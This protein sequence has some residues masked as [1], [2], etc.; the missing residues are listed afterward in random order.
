[1]AKPSAS[2]DAQTSIFSNPQDNAAGIP[3]F[4]E[5]CNALYERE[6]T[7]L[8]LANYRDITLL[9]RR[10]RGLPY[11]IK[12]AARF[13]SSQSTPL[14]VDVHNAS[15]I[16]KQSSARPQVNADP[17]VTRKWF[18]QH[19]KFGLA[20]PVLVKVTENIHIELDSID[21]LDTNQQTLHTNKFGWFNF[22]GNPV[23]NTD[24]LTQWQAQQ[25]AVLKPTK[26]IMTAALCGHVWNHKGKTSPRRLGLREVLL[27]S[28]V[29]WNSFNQVISTLPQD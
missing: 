13:I 1:M 3:D 29:Q 14:A 22:S 16:S 6:L 11:H 21:I 8:G 27:A 17:E 24:M 7:S 28:T 5:L 25:V 4:A 18:Q 15:W 2:H 9:Q 10:L 26:T 19:A 12:R 23:E 20:I